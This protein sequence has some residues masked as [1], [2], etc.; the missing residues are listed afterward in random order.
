M[1]AKN[2][3]Q[4]MIK[5]AQ[6]AA[7]H[8]PPILAKDRQ[9]QHMLA[10]NLIKFANDIELLKSIISLQTGIPVDELDEDSILSELPLEATGLSDARVT[11]GLDDLDEV[12]ITMELENALKKDLRSLDA[13]YGAKNINTIGDLSAFLKRSSNKTM[14]LAN[15]KQ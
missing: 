6:Q 14:R 2:L 11:P 10:K 9:R 5:Q 1:L 13:G 15:L 7:Y 4:F 12:E 8:P 3:R